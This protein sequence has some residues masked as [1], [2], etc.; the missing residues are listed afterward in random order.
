LWYLQNYYFVVDPRVL[1]RPFAGRVASALGWFAS[2]RLHAS[3]FHLHD[4]NTRH[5]I[6]AFVTT[7]T[8]TRVLSPATRSRT[9]TRSAKPDRTRWRV[10]TRIHHY[11]LPAPRL[12]YTFCIRSPYIVAVS[13]YFSRHLQE[14]ITVKNGEHFVFYYGSADLPVVASFPAR[15]FFFFTY[16]PTYSSEWPYRQDYRNAI[17]VLYFFVVHNAFRTWARV[18][19]P[20]SFTNHSTL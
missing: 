9:Q 15:R 17:R 6:T 3:H 20:F 14:P 5:R 19:L 10:A 18:A 11:H 7:T 2:T 13:T 12:H 1:R 8:C 4:A 16:V